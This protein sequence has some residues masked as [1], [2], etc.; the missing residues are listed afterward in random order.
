MENNYLPSLP[1]FVLPGLATNST[2]Q[3]QLR[4]SVRLY[5][6]LGCQ[7]LNAQELETHLQS[8][9]EELVQHL[10]QSAPPTADAIHH[11]RVVLDMA[12]NRILQSEEEVQQLLQE[13]VADPSGMSAP[14]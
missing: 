3:R 11:A 2:W 10:L 6:A 8:T 13:L 7:P 9:E 14:T 12:Q 4:Q 1:S 5:L